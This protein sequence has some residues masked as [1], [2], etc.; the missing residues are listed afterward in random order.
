MP[1]LP[2]WY[3][4][5]N[6]CCFF[7]FILFIFM[8]TSGCGLLYTNVVKPYSA[9]FNHTPAGAKQC[10]L[11]SYKIQMPV[12]PLFRTRVSA[13]WDTKRMQDVAQKAGITKIYYTDIKTQEVFLGTYRRQTV[14]IYGD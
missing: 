14:I 9:D 7:L 13:E 11:S 1:V 10:T 4:V 2:R 3:M 6:R 5:I 8:S 12:P